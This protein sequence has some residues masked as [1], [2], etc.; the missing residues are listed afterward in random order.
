MP[1]KTLIIIAGIPSYI[2]QEF[3]RKKPNLSEGIREIIFL[4]IKNN[5]TYS[6]N[7][8]RDLYQL[9]SETV[10]RILPLDKANIDAPNW[11]NGAIT[12]YFEIGET[13][14]TQLI[15]AFGAETF[16]VPARLSST[17]PVG[18]VSPNLIANIANNTI[19]TLRKLIR[20][21]EAI[22]LAIS[23]EVTSNAN[24][25]PLLL[26][27]V[28]YGVSEIR[29]LRDQIMNIIHARDEYAALRAVVKQFSS[30][31]KL[32]RFGATRYWSFV[33]DR[34]IVFCRPS[35]LHGFNWNLGEGHN[36]ACY[37]RSRLRFGSCINPRFHYDC[38][39]RRGALPN[40]WSSCHSQTVTLQKAKSHI[41]ISPN[42][43]VR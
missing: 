14:P 7:Y 16:V 4:P 20:K 2:E 17:Q 3:N 24:R 37:V 6:A 26:P 8:I 10:E 1:P 32:V 5:S 43:Y 21:A 12:I 39:R 23:K 25:T 42:D 30:K 29:E 40:F 33:N 9:F 41:N 27:F 18:N 34:D 15:E 28:N 13:K 36:A 31:A 38:K 19:R 35:A 22:L 11:F